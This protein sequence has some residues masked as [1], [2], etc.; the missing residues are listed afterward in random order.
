[1]TDQVIFQHVTN[2]AIKESSEKVR[3]L[4][5]VT[6]QCCHWKESRFEL[7]WKMS[8]QALF[9]ISSAGLF[10]M[11]RQTENAGYTL[12]GLPHTKWKYVKVP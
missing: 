2:K 1:M 9:L 12:R 8:D 7:S 10:S 5:K 6:Y 3:E 11:H 4:L